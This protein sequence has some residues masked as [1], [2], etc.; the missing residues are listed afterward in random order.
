MKCPQ[1]DILR[2]VHVDEDGGERKEF[3]TINRGTTGASRII[4]GPPQRLAISYRNV[5]YSAAQRIA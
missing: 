3:P 5:T 1:D 2:A 4:V